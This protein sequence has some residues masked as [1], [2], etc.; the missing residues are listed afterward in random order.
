MSDIFP[1]ASTDFAFSEPP[2]PTPAS[3]TEQ[4]RFSGRG[5]EYFRIWIVNLLLSVITVGIYS[6]WAKVRKLRYFYDNTTLAGTSFEYHGNPVAILKGR[7]IALVMLLIYQYTIRFHPTLVWLPLLILFALMPW[8]IWRSLQF[9][10][11]NSSYRGIRFGFRGS[12]AGA[13]KVYLGLP[14]LTVLT[15][16]VLGPFT[17]QRMKRFQHNESRFGS[18]HFSFNAPVGGFY[19]AY[20]IGAVFFVAGLAAIITLVISSSAL[21]FYEDSRA[22]LPATITKIF[23]GIYAWG[24]LIYPVLMSM[25]QNLIWN[26]T[27]LG[28]HQFRSKLRWQRLLWLMITNSLGIVFTL[29]LFTPFAQIRTLRYRIESLQIEATGTL[30]DFIAA[31]EANGSATGEGF[32]DLLDFDLSL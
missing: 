8:M 28:Q 11:Y 10:L 27:Q 4:L 18:T 14:L 5:G 25:L 22:G 31:T 12:A 7:I 30:D 15:L 24:F 19:K 16:Y 1:P 26:H 32:S 21:P 29:G 17:H 3:T 9:K 2:L 13:Y 20:L 23:I 6:A